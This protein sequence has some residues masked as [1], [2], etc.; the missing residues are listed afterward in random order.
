MQL[1]TDFLIATTTKKSHA[2]VMMC[3]RCTGGSGFKEY[4]LMYLL[5][6]NKYLQNESMRSQVLQQEPRGGGHDIGWGGRGGHRF[7]QE[8]EFHFGFFSPP[9]FFSAVTSYS[10]MAR[11]LLYFTVEMLLSIFFLSKT[12]KL[13]VL[14]WPFSI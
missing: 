14:K 7:R 2:G 6:F 4:F 13:P 11:S 12:G 9:F 3:L 10:L 5:H 8:P 1:I